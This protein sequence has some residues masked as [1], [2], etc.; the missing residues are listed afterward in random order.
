M[1]LVNL[2]IRRP[3]LVT[4]VP[5]P[6]ELGEIRS[7]DMDLLLQVL[8]IAQA[9]PASTTAELMSRLYATPYGNQLTEIFGREFIT[10]EEGIA[11]KFSQDLKLLVDQYQQRKTRNATLEQLRRLH[12]GTESGES[13]QLQ[14]S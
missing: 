2:L 8:E 5:I 14:G 1:R 4:E 11:E 10:P 13:G 7:P 9:W 12:E 6:E 3:N